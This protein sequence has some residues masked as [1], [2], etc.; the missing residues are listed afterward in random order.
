MSESKG[1]NKVISQVEVHQFVIKSIIHC[2]LAEYSLKMVTHTVPVHTRI[3][4][5]KP[6]KVHTAN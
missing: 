2:L 6:T 1:A 3:H 5:H 4:M